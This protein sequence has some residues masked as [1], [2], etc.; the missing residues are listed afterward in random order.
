MLIKFQ[1]K[2]L[3]PSTN[4]KYINK[5]NILNKNKA[6]IDRVPIKRFA[7]CQFNLKFKH[8]IS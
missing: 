3:I 2:L 5:K 4:Q 1:L 6:F 7:K 8:M